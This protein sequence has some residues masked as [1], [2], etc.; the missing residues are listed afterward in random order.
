MAL[1]RRPAGL[2]KTEEGDPPA[3]GL[4]VMYSLETITADADRRAGLLGQSQN[5]QPP[6]K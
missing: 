3:Q 4:H 2:L 5:R 6:L 1:P